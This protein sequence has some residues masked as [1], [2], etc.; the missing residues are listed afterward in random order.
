MESS[1]TT[2]EPISGENF[3]SMFTSKTSS[4][5]ANYRQILNVCIDVLSSSKHGQPVNVSMRKIKAISQYCGVAYNIVNSAEGTL[6]ID[7]ALSQHLLPI[8][9]G[10][11]ANFGDRLEN[12]HESLNNLTGDLSNTTEK[13]Q[14]MIDVGRNNFDTYSLLV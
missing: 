5:P 13:L 9:N 2:L 6:A 1:P 4:M 14:R 3:L 8:L 10:H 11:G 7:Y 12:L